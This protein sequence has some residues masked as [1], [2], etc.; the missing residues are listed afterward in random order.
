[1]AK[2][3][4]L[5]AELYEKAKQYSQSSGYASVDEFVSHILEKEISKI[6]VEGDSMEEVQN[7][8]RGLGY[9]S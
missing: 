7:R 4:K 2:K 6:E 3:I 9:I 8:L 1:M 5:E